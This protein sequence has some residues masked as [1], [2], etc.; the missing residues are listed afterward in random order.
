MFPFFLQ[1]LLPLPEALCFARTV[2]T[3][4]GQTHIRI[5]VRFVV[6]YVFPPEPLPSLRY[7]CMYQSVLRKADS[8]QFVVAD[9]VSPPFLRS[10]SLCYSIV[11]LFRRYAIRH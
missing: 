8:A 10:V 9:I 1:F 6:P 11:L 7:R 2:R 5:V 4:A 3:L